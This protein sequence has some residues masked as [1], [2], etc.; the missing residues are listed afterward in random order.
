MTENTRQHDTRRRVGALVQRLRFEAMRR[1][2]A[3]AGV[4]LA[5]GSLVGVGARSAVGMAQLEAMQTAETDRKAEVERVHGALHSGHQG[6]ARDQ[7]GGRS[8]GPPA[9]PPTAALSRR[10]ST[11]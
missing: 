6:T 10:P 5:L 4:L 11:R 9:T 7:P 3:A 8:A 1:P 2:L